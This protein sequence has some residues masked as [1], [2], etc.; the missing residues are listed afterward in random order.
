MAPILIFFDVPTFTTEI[1]G[2]QEK[3][4]FGV[5]NPLVEGWLEIKEDGGGWFRLWKKFYFILEQESQEIRWYGSMNPTEVSVM[6]T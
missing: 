5:N 1:V 2:M 6:W 3:E 4:L